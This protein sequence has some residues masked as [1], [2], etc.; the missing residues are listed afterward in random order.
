MDDDTAGISPRGHR[1]AGPGRS[2]RKR[3]DII[4]TATVLFLRYGYHGTSMD[5]IAAEAGV[6]KQT[7][8]KNFAD[9]EQL[10]SDIVL[11][12][13][14]NS[15]AIIRELT[16]VLRSA[17]IKT[18][19]DLMAV[20]TELARRYL[21][22]VLQPH[23]LALRRLVI[24]EAERFPDLA[25]SYYEQAPARGIEIIAQHLQAF[26]YRGMLQADDSYL[27]ATPGQVS[28]LS[29]PAAQLSR[30]RTDRQR[31]CPRVPCRL[32]AFCGWQPAPSDAGANAVAA[33]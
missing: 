4:D 1:T 12:V 16:S 5:Q 27:A 22:A 18:A 6:S 7:V 20:L 13:T 28:V 3:Q 9:K 33:G 23:V 32:R 8:Y 21:D 15:D 2:A 26:I 19:D 10:F 17:E 25:R 14:R 30:T 29:P 31:S 11:G 24:A